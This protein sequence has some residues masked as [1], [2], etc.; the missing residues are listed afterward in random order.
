MSN[1]AVVAIEREPDIIAARQRGR[2]LASVA[3]FRGSDL[4]LIATAISELARNIVAYAKRGSVSLRVIDEA[5]RRGIEVIAED[6]GPGIANIEL[7]LQDGYSTGKSLGLGLPGARRIMDE[8]AIES[9]L[10]RGTRVC[11]RKWVRR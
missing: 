6:R 1:D 2:E 5:G 7:A 8:F 9:Q 3:G 11:A 4:T 10:G